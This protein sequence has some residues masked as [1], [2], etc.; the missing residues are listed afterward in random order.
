MLIL[1]V[2]GLAVQANVRPAMREISGFRPDTSQHEPEDTHPLLLVAGADD[3][4]IAIPVS[5]VTRLERVRRSAVE[6]CGGQRVVQYR[7]G[8]LPLVS[9][10]ELLPERRREPR[11]AA[12][13]REL[14]EV[15]EMIVHTKDGR[16]VG[17]VVERILDTIEHAIAKALPASRKGVVGSVVIQGRVTEILDLDVMCEELPG[18][19]GLDLFQEA[20]V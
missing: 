20:T 15:M 19:A 16:R 6:R 11:G 14:N 5:Q 1:D 2:L 17:V 13:T 4:R 18:S 10:S 9:L 3:A 8:I 12:S 7:G